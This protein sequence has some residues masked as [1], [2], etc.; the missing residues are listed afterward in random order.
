MKLLSNGSK[1]KICNVEHT[2]RD[3][4]IIKKPIP[5]TDLYKLERLYKALSGFEVNNAVVARDM[6]PETFIIQIN[7]FIEKMTDYN[8]QGIE[9]SNLLLTC[10]KEMQNKA[11]TNKINVDK[12]KLEKVLRCREF[13]NEDKIEEKID[14]LVEDVRDNPFSWLDEMDIEDLSSYI[15]VDEVIKDLVDSNGYYD[16]LN[17]NDGG[18][19]TIDWDNE[20]YHIMQTNG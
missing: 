20:T 9:K 6:I 1:Y 8:I 5:M 18:G 11:K 7:G 17:G 12:E 4:L 3:N 16:I 2:I 14:E 19:D 13:L 15:D 10:Y